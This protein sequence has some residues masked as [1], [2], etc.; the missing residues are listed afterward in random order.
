[1]EASDSYNWCLKNFKDLC[2]SCYN[3]RD[4]WSNVSSLPCVIYVLKLYADLIVS[5]CLGSTV[6]IVRMSVNDKLEETWKEVVVTY[7]NVLS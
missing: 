5:R 6:L 2:R 3:A 4:V 1:V 7:F